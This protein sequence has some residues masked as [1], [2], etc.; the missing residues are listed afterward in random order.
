MDNGGLAAALD[1]I[2]CHGQDNDG[3]SDKYRSLLAAWLH[4][5]EQVSSIRLSLLYFSLLIGCLSSLL[6][7]SREDKNNCG[8]GCGSAKQT[9]QVL[10]KNSYQC[11]QPQKNQSCPYQ[12]AT[13]DLNFLLDDGTLV[14]AS[15]EAVAGEEGAKEVGSDYFRALLMGGFGEAQKAK[16]EAICI[17]DVNIGMLLPV[18]HYLHGCRLTDGNEDHMTEGSKQDKYCPVLG[19]LGSV[20][21]GRLQDEMESSFQTTPLANVMIGA[22]RFLVPGL[23]RASED[24]CVGLLSSA[25]SS[26]LRSR[27]RCCCFNDISTTSGMDVDFACKAQTHPVLEKSPQLSKIKTIDAPQAVPRSL[28]KRCKQHSKA[29]KLVEKSVSSSFLDNETEGAWLKSLLPQVYWFSQRYSYLRLGQACLSML[30]RPQGF[31][32]AALH[33]SLSADCFLRLAQ[34][35]DCTDGLRRDILNLVKTALS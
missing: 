33:P 19:S 21:L 24:L 5:V 25:F 17:K 15:H 23:Q 9:N 28:L 6:S 11:S 10:D 35:A 13:H 12:E 27:T 3:L 2:G 20:G 1:L 34:E 26:V 29:S 16:G 14:P 31:H 18:L 8:S 22:C 4:P 32:P 7:N 30:L